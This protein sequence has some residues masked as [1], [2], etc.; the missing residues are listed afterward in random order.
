MD[1]PVH[2]SPLFGGWVITRHA[3][4]ISILND[5]TFVADDPIA[6]F[7]RIEE[8]G[9]PSLPH[10]R[11]V[12]ASVSFYTQPPRHI[13]LRKFISRLFQ[14]LEMTG[15]RAALEGRAR[16]LLSDARQTGGLDLASGYGGDLALFAIHTLLGLP[17]DDCVALAEKVRGIAWIFDMSPRSLREM[18]HAE[19]QV[20]KILDYF[21]PEILRRRNRGEA[22]GLSLLVRLADSEL[23]LCDRDLAGFCAFFFVGGQE[24][25]ATGIAASALMLLEQGATRARLADDPAKLAGAAR[26]F[27]RLAAPFQYVVRVAGRDLTMGGEAIRSGDRVNLILGAA[28]RDP[29]A[30][31]DPDGIDSERTGSE[32]L[33]FGHGA[34]RCL[35]A[36]LAQI[37]TEVALAGLLANPDLQLAPET[38]AWEKRTRVPAL[39]RAWARFT[40]GGAALG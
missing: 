16:A 20:G 33:A 14:R 31:P 15:L 5:P 28:N 10:L 17:W 39:A 35:G 27:L 36:R 37:E 24:T 1:A 21:E 19:A 9:G 34:Y 29:A 22:D 30:F 26:E 7:T 40:D 25:T 8:R 18:A 3:D 32:S 38:V 12:L 6:R 11:T 13:L 23:D 2:W 4:A